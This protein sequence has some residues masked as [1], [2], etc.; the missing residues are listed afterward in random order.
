MYDLQKDIETL[1]ANQKTKKYSKRQMEKLRKDVK[2]I[3]L[4][5]EKQEEEVRRLRLEQAYGIGS[6]S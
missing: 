4:R 3:I 6:H 1:K 5:N 2:K